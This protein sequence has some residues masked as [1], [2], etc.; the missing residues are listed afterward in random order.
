MNMINFVT[1]AR[2]EPAVLVRGRRIVKIVTTVVLTGY[3]VTLA[4]VLGWWGVESARKERV[5]SEADRLQAWVAQL[6]E[7]EATVRK[8]EDRARGVNG[9]LEGRVEMGAA[10][11]MLGQAAV[12]AWSY[13]TKNK[14]H[15]VTITAPN[16]FEIEGFMSR[17]GE[18]T[19]QV[20]LERATFQAGVWEGV[21][22]F[23]DS[24]PERKLQ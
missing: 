16:A 1:P 12:L 20:R 11:Q 9:F 15:T 8:M 22:S 23:S 10:G 5:S 14:R 19:G 2:Q 13:E 4:G 6:S 24:A 17:V 7:T 3:V 21:V 18:S